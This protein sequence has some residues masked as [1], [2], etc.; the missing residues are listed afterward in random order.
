VAP[1]L[2]V[3]EA[4]LVALVEDG[5]APQGE[6]QDQGAAGPVGMA[7]GPAGGEARDVVVGPGPDG[8]GAGGEAGRGA[9]P[10]RP[11]AGGRDR[12]AVRRT[13]LKARCSSSPP[14]P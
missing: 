7:A 4:E 13:K 2:G 8:P 6:E 9:L 14:S 12:G 5:G 3:D 11:Q 1:Q 10:H